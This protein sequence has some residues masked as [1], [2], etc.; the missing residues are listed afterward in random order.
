MSF[1]SEAD[2]L[3]SIK[4]LGGEPFSTGHAEKLIGVFDRP[5]VD[6]FGQVIAVKNRKPELLVRESD[7]S[8]HGL[9][10]QSLITRDSDGA[11]YVVRDLDPDGTGMTV[12]ALGT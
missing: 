4:A 8:K 7:V 5:S 9:V 6:S 2:R 10:K 12:I 3:A 1:E 11:S